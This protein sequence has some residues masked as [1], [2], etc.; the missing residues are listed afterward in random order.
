MRDES[1]S[2]DVRFARRG[3]PGA[4][5]TDPATVDAL[6]DALA[7]ER[8]R[9]ILEYVLDQSEPV[10]LD[11]LAERLHGPGSAPPSTPGLSERNRLRCRLYHAHLP[12]LDDAGIVEFDRERNTVRPSDDA[13]RIAFCRD[14][15]RSVP[16]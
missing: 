15:L 3:S 10:G 5:G 16:A 12:R 11:E 8:R 9:V 14:L 4:T 1:T 13:R 2:V 6:F 7:D